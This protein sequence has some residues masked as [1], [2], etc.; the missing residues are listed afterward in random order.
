MYDIETMCREKGRQIL[1]VLFLN[2]QPLTWFHIVNRV[3]AITPKPYGI[4]FRKFT[5]A[6]MTLR[7]CVMNIEDNSCL[8]GL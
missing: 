8:F 5:D 4:Y 6:C 2:Y 1:L 3:W 7:R